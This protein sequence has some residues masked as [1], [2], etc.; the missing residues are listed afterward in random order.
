MSEKMRFERGTNQKVSPSVRFAK[1]WRGGTGPR[2]RTEIRVVP[3]CRVP[4]ERRCDTETK[5]CVTGLSL[6]LASLHAVLYSLYIPV[7]WSPDFNLRQPPRVVRAARLG[8]DRA[9]SAQ[10]R[11]RRAT[12]LSRHA[13]VCASRP[14][15]VGHEWQ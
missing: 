11:V 1:R 12:V 10:R 3:E 15:A 7:R 9:T 13:C 6:M 8:G 14:K 4:R 2:H 5:E